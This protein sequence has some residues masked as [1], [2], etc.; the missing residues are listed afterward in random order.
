MAA[1]NAVG[2]P[3][4]VGSP[5]S[6]VGS[7]VVVTDKQQIK[8]M[9]TLLKHHFDQMIK[10]QKAVSRG[11]KLT[12]NKGPDGAI[13]NMNG[14]VVELSAR[15]VGKYQTMVFAMHNEI[16]K[17]ATSLAG[18]KKTRKSSNRFP[19]VKYYHAELQMFFRT[20]DLGDDTQSNLTHLPGQFSIA[21]RITLIGGNT[22]GPGNVECP[23]IGVGA[24][25]TDGTV[26]AGGEGV[27]SPYVVQN[28]LNLYSNRKR[29]FYNA[30][31]NAN[32]AAPKMKKGVPVL[33]S[34]GVAVPVGITTGQWAADAAMQQAFAAGFQALANQAGQ[35]KKDDA[36]K[37]YDAFSADSIQQKNL[38]SLISLYSK[39]ASEVSPAKQ[40]L[41][42]RP[43][44]T[45]EDKQE[46]TYFVEAITLT[47]VQIDAREKRLDDLKNEHKEARKGQG[48][49]INKADVVL[50]P[51]WIQF[52]SEHDVQYSTVRDY[53]VARTGRALSPYYLTVLSLY[54]QRQEVSQASFYA[55]ETARAEI[56]V[57][58]GRA[59]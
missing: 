21:S 36:T 58:L 11:G 43:S 24:F 47:K 34:N 18:K 19:P 30:P 45:A 39:D 22:S 7:P 3:A 16:L 14:S 29:L 20:A 41:L 28:L 12:L 49:K 26:A 27:S 4:T 53:V 25:N 23:A 1:F 32:P 35:P 37:V 51:A 5:V 38:L 2:S 15:V 54:I 6:G 9:N 55:R 46:N 17:A 57:H 59:H 33:D 10:I 13:L 44:A 56:A 31:V 42:V 50:T 48:I 52:L 8:D 40:S